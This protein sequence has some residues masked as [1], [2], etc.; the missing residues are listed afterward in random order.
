MGLR[1]TKKERSRREIL[2]A[3]RELFFQNGY[4]GTTVEAVAGK[5]QVAVGTVYNY[6]ESKSALILAITAMDLLKDLGEDFDTMPSESGLDAIIR[7]AENS[8]GIFSRYP[9]ELLREL[10]R[11]A[12]GGRDEAL[13]GGFRGQDITMVER[14]ARILV[15]LEGSGRL[16]RD[17]DAG[18]AALV[19]YG[20]L[21]TSMIWYAADQRRTAR[22]MMESV[23]GMLGTLYGG[24]EPKGDIL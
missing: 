21:I 8:I 12:V 20:I 24:L 11:E 1:D 2:E 17:I 6:F 15:D 7:F 5:A 10:L 22:E 18:M 3:A 13:G 23:R 14:L 4:A 9:R 19:I 16:R